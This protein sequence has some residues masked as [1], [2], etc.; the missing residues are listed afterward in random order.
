M[1]YTVE[2]TP[3]IGSGSGSGVGDG[4]YS[5]DISS[6]EYTTDYIWFVNVTDGK[7]WTRKVFVFKTQPLMVFDPYDE[8]WQYRKKITIDHNMVAGDLSD[9]PVLVSLVDYDFAVKAQVDGDDILLMNGSGVTSRLFHEIEYF[10]SSTGELIAWVKIPD[11]DDNADTILYLYYGN[12]YCAN[13]EY[14]EMVWN[15]DYIAVYHMDGEEYIDIDDSTSNNLDVIEASGDPIYQESG[16]V[17]FCVDFDNDSLNVGDN[18][19]LSFT[20]GSNH[21]TPVTIEAWVKCDIPGGDFN[22]IISKYAYSHREWEFRKVGDGSERGMLRF[23]D[24]SSLATIRRYSE[25]SLNVNDNGWNYIS[26][27]YDGGESGSDISFVFDGVVEEGDQ[28]T[29]SSYY[30]ME[31][32]N[33]KMRFGA[34]HSPN[35]DKWFYWQGLIDEVRISK[36]VRSSEWL[37]TGYNS[38]NDPSSFFSVGPE[39]LSP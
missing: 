37:I 12:P 32:R 21:D 24:E 4:V 1:D 15:S 17:G 2:T 22:P 9:F 36:I 5:I 23:A 28:E 10:E 39:E 13:Q 6:L 26:G 33:E 14:P 19:L 11:L 31:N 35:A 16:I 38:M 7:Y 34:L 8:G 18:D 29:G 20:D 3:D 30:G 25:S 27:A